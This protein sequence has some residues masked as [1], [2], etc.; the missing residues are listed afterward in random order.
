MQHQ[1]RQSD[2][3]HQLEGQE[4]ELK[5]LNEIREA[6]DKLPANQ[7]VV[8]LVTF[9]KRHGSVLADIG[10]AKVSLE[11]AEMEMNVKRQRLEDNAGT[12]SKTLVELEEVM[13][14]RRE[15]KRSEGPETREL[16]KLLG[17]KKRVVVLVGA[18]ISVSA[19]SKSSSAIGLAFLSKS[20]S[21]SG[22]SLKDWNILQHGEKIQKIWRV[23]FS[24]IGIQGFRR[25]F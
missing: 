21:S 3:Q 5:G 13:E 4:L 19:G 20:M 22:F 23:A 14:A 12:I 10:R 25:H 2:L 16:L 6:M 15:L 18:G 9:G 8:D 24:G 11:E 1:K 7:K 17:G